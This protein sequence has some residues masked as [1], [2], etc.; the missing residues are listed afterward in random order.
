MGTGHRRLTGAPGSV[1]FCP[2]SPTK[3]PQCLSQQSPS[4][5]SPSETPGTSSLPHEVALRSWLPGA[6]PAG[7][8]SE[9]RVSRG[10]RCPTPAHL[11][12]P[13]A[14]GAA[15]HME[16]RLF[17]PELGR[18]PMAQDGGARCC[19]GSR[20]LQGWQRASEAVRRDLVASQWGRGQGRPEHED[21][22]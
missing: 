17:S 4:C 22:A 5:F 2:R 7:A 10:Q 20:P 19:T 11:G 13:R 12:H 6:K 15:V 3:L 21:R 8:S 9:P 18:V 14:W 16:G 1:R